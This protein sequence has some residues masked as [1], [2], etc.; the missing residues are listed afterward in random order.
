MLVDASADAPRM[1]TAEGRGVVLLPAADSTGRVPSSAG[2]VYVCT[3]ET[4]DNR[5]NEV[6]L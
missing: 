1:A 2:S 5:I 4:A 6:T 3:Y